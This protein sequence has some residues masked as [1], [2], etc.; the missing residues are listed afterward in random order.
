MALQFK[1]LPGWNFT[2]DEVSAG[3]YKV[4][5]KDP[6]GRSVER[7]GTDPDELIEKC[8]DYASRIVNEKAN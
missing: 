4:I 6:A 8:K 2:V 7:I 5:G 3:V 1:E